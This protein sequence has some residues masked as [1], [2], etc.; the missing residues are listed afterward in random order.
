MR[1]AAEVDLA[2]ETVHEHAFSLRSLLARFRPMLLGGLVLVV[3]DAV[4]SLAAPYLV[5]SG[6]DGGVQAHA[7]GYLLAAA[8]ALLVVTLVDLAV[9]IASVFV[10]GRLAERIMLSLRLRIWAQLQRLSLDYYERELAGRI[11]TRMTTDVDQFEQLV[12]N[13][14]LNA[15]VAVVTFVGVGISLLVVDLELGLI[16][17]SVLVPLSVATVWFRRRAS[18]LYDL[19]RERIAVVNAQF[20]ENLAGIRESQAFVHEA[21]S[22]RQFH[23]LGESYLRSRV[24]AQRLVATYF[25]FVQFLSSVADALVLGVGAYLIASGSLTVGALIA[26]LLFIDLFF[27][28][29]QQLSQVF[30]AWQQT[31]VSVHRI[32]ELMALDPLTPRAAPRRSRSARRTA[33]WTSNRCASPTRRR[34]GRRAGTR[35]AVSTCTSPPARRWRWSVRPV[36]A[37]RPCSNC[38][39][40]STT[41]RRGGCVSMAATCAR[42][43]SGTSAGTSATCRRSRSCSPAPSGPTS[44]TAGRRRATPRSRRR[45]GP[46]GRTR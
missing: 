9:S 42:W 15:L 26:F 30:D 4:L 36:P 11:M 12:S 2:A 10:T 23:A 31:R 37:S 34:S 41:R 17:L 22:S 20:Q 43:G 5:K 33:G 1:D 14:L 18:R 40:A 21:A 46:S 27:T 32:A 13:G 16:T 39:P 3:L 19:S 38:W 35:S 44:P 7:Q 45:P 8:L 28:P 29:I 24:A 6:V 25:P